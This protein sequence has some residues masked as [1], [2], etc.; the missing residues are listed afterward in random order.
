MIAE[1]RA[2]VTAFVNEADAAIALGKQAQGALK[3]G[4][5]RRSQAAYDKDQSRVYYDAY[6]WHDGRWKLRMNYLNLGV[7]K[8]AGEGGM[9]EKIDTLVAELEQYRK[10]AETYRLV[11]A[12]AM[13]A[14]V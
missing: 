4:G 14:S 7:R 3:E 6:K 11:L 13:G 10:N 2:E 5:E 12:N 8:T 9:V 1:F